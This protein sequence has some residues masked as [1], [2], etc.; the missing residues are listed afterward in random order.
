MPVS[1]KATSPGSIMLM[2]EHAVVY[3]HPAL[4]C[5]IDRFITVTLRPRTDKR[6]HITSENFPAYQTDIAHLN[7]STPYQFVLT[8]IFAVQT[9]LT[10]GFDLVITSNMSHQQGLGSS[11]AV[12]VATVKVLAEFLQQPLT[13]TE[14]L[15]QARAVVRKV[16]GLGSGTDVA[17][18]VYGGIVFYKPEP[19][20]VT[21]LDIK[22]PLSL[23]YCGMKTPTANVIAK[24][25]DRYEL[26]PQL[27]SA[28][29]I[30]IG[31]CVMQAYQALIQQDFVKLGMIMNIHQGLQV[32]LGVS[33]RLL[34]ELLEDLRRH[35]K[36]L[37]A[38]ISG[39]GLGDC[40]LGLGEI[41][42]DYFPTTPKQHQLG[43]CVLPI[44][45]ANR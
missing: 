7:I 29:F 6:I 8:A 34:E 21:K 37:G 5:A 31:H 1:Y 44:K 19:L 45:V 33:N 4:A 32:S 16:Q 42:P 40:V 13:Q 41:E 28:I 30:Q 2:G 9:Q 3:G 25:R 39:S 43:V 23:V 24:V 35:P 36:I 20:E 11:A 12:T 15:L 14:L 17:A 22:L 27:I 38:K 10:Q 18:S 26:C